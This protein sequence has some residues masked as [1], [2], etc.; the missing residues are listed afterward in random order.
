MSGARQ[1]PVS[2][3]CHGP[4][5]GLCQ[6]PVRGLSGACVRGLCQETL[7]AQE[8]TKSA[9][10]SWSIDF[11]ILWTRSIVVQFSLLWDRGVASSTG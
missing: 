11:D 7:T 4:V 8:R 5:R 2:G 6:G 1:G 10:S 3:A 9:A